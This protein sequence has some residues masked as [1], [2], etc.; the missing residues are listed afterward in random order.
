MSTDLTEV[1]FD[2][3]DLYRA[4]FAKALAYKTNFKTSNNITIDPEK[5]KLNKA[6]FSSQNVIG[7]LYKHDLLIS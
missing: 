6:V 4:E 7:L 2:R 3:C 1:V 5:T